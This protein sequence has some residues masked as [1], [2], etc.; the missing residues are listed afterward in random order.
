MVPISKIGAVK[1]NVESSAASNHIT[2]PVVSN[3]GAATVSV[4][5]LEVLMTHPTFPAGSSRLSDAPHQEVSDP[6]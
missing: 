2:N 1:S 3:G 6:T 5:A 4:T